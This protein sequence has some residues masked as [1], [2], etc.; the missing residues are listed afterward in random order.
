MNI[1][2][3][4]NLACTGDARRKRWLYGAIAGT[5]LAIGLAAQFGSPPAVML[6]D[7]MRPDAA[8]HVAL[9]RGEEV[10][11]RFARGVTLLNER[12]YAGAANELHRLLELAPEMPEAHVNM[13]F[14]MIGLQRYPVAK[15]FFEV[16]IQLRANQVNAYYGLALAL[17]G[18]HDL[19]GAIGAMRS[20]VHL[21]QAGDPYLPKANAMISEWQKQ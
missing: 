8:E 7:K 11:R 15:S 16:A 4:L 2:R 13:G 14:A 9:K 20:Y 5:A 19:P 3:S 21:S 10:G 18:A 17:Q 12:Q 1:G 6:G